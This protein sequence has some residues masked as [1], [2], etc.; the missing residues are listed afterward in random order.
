MNTPRYVSFVVR[1]KT[2]LGD[3]VTTR[4]VMLGNQ[5]MEEHVMLSTHHELSFNEDEGRTW[6]GERK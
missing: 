6:P 1:R 4:V 2:A 3:T 5:L